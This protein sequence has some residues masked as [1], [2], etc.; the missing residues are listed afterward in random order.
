MADSLLV[1]TI[2]VLV[3]G[4]SQLVVSQICEL[5]PLLSSVNKLG[6][7]SS[8]PAK[9][10]KDIYINNIAS[11]GKSGYY[12]IKTNDEYRVYCDMELTCG[13]ITGGWMRIADIDTNRGDD[14]PTGWKKITQPQPLCRGS[15][16]AAGCYSAYFSN[17]KTEY[18]STEYNS[19]CG[20]LR[21][22][23]QGTTAAFLAKY[24]PSHSID[25]PYLDGVSI[26]VGN[27]RKHVWSYGTGYSKVDRHSTY[28][29]PRVVNCPCAK[30][31]GAKPPIY[32]Q[33]HYY[34]ESGSTHKPSSFT[35]FY[36]SD[37][38]WDGRGCPDGDD[39]CSTLGAPW[40][41]R[42]FTEP[43]SGAVEVRICRDEPYSN[44]ATLVEQ[45]ELYVQ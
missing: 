21:G 20:K 36:G 22:Y 7:D 13:G 34:C 43:E 12:W 26:T 41:Y 17:N 31:P 38:L 39:C 11:R 45:V 35:A 3:V 16:D 27:P 19:I 24:A 37:P 14:C 23:Q 30:Y 33:R 8:H 40:F 29:S 44:E 10:C 1:Y 2:I 6:T 25:A 28:N 32:V 42:Y 5:E 9:S 18:N 4:Y 15:G